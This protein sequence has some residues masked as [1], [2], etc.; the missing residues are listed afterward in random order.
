M[1]YL[2]IILFSCGTVWG[3]I[4]KSGQ[5]NKGTKESGATK[6]ASGSFFEYNEVEYYHNNYDESSI[7][8]LYDNQSGSE[9]DSF[10]MGVIL[11]DIPKDISDLSFIP[12]LGKIVYTRRIMSKDKFPEL[13]KILREKHVRENI[14][15]SCIY[16][17]R[18][19][20]IFKKNNKV[21]GTVKI[22]FDCMAHEITGT[23]ANT[24]NFGQDGD[25]EKL[26]A[27][28]QQYQQ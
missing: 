26:Q 8:D 17:Y 18:D 27:L 2:L 11:G 16:V 6:S 1:K 3:C 9:L 4:S 19:I 22:C 21:T 7:G 13:D 14:T 28:L 24:R 23:T 25:Y 15:A 20:L 10:K 12:K 5:T